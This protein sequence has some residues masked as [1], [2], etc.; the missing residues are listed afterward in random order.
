LRKYY[1]Q[2]VKKRVVVVWNLHIRVH[3]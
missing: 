1:L 2:S 3:N